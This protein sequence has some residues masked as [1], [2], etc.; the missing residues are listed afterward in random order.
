LYVSGHG[1]APD[2]QQAYKYGKQA[3]D[4][5]L[6]KGCFDL[7]AV[8][9]HDRGCTQALEYFAKACNGGIPEGCNQA[10]NYSQLQANQMQALKFYKM[11]CDDGNST[12]CKSYAHLLD[13]LLKG[14]MRI[15]NL[16]DYEQATLYNKKACDLGEVNACSE[17]G[18]L[19]SYA[20][21]IVQGAS[22]NNQ[23]ALKYYNMACEDGELSV[24]FRLGMLFEYGHSNLLADG[25]SM[26][27][28]PQQ[29]RSY[30]RK[31]CDKKDES[32][33]TMLQTVQKSVRF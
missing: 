24:C 19:L 29:G 16:Q 9:I 11:S 1:V 18:F 8:C 13:D 25:Q 31:A 30:W 7:G 23:E 20:S 10:A 17:A 5:G 27:K 21:T 12:G 22:P 32:A 4:G 3:C 26:T 14:T 2:Y 15:G 33:C 6:A 28:D